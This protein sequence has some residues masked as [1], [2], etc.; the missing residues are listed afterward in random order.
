[1]VQRIE[2]ISMVKNKNKSLIFPIITVLFLCLF[3]SGC[4]FDNGINNSTV[5]FKIVNNSGDNQVSSNISVYL[6]SELIF[7][8]TVSFYEEE[9]RE[10]DLSVKNGKHIVKAIESDT[11]TSLSKEFEITSEI[12]IVITYLNGEYSENPKFDFN[13]YDGNVQYE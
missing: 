12:S 8:D 10:I 6:D 4:V 1:M 11:S 5:H 13:T 9:W 2:V 7:N 3:T